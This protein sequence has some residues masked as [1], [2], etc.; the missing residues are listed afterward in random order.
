M[1][2]LFPGMLAVLLLSACVGGPRMAEPARYDLGTAAGGATLWHMPPA[3]IEVQASSWLSAT[4]MH[5]RLAYADPLRRQG[6]IES[7][8]AAP[9]AEL[10]E[11]LLKRRQGRA[12][13]GGPAC[14]LQVVLD[15]FEQRFDAPQSSQM[16]LEARAILLPARGGDMLARRSFQIQ[17][18][19]PTA[20]ARGGAAAARE[21]ALALADELAAWANGLDSTVLARCRN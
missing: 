5:Y 21:A 4:A 1:N 9:P 6:Y 10:L 2:K 13:A 20:D 19:S 14:R 3:A 11:S 16:A 17:K 8:W 12:E 15:E 7:R 18:P